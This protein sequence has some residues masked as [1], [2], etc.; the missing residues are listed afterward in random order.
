MNQRTLLRGWGPTLTAAGVCV[1][2]GF[3]SLYLFYK[4]FTPG[5]AG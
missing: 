2:C 4:A 1:G 5:V 3:L